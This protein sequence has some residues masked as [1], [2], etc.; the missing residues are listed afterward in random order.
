MSEVKLRRKSFLVSMGAATLGWMGV[1]ANAKPAKPLTIS[2]PSADQN[3]LHLRKDS[4]TVQYSGK[5]L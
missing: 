4:R 1:R 2:S 3:G 5:A